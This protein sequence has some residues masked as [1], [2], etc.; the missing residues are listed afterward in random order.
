MRVRRASADAEMKEAFYL[1]TF[2]GLAFREILLMAACSGSEL[3]K[4]DSRA[5]ARS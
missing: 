3:F 2:D 5:V 1:H 4:V